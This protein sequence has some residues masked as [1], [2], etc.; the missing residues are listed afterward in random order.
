MALVKTGSVGGRCSRALAVLG[1]ALIAWLAL[2]DLPLRA[3]IAG[4][5]QYEIKAAFL[6]NFAKFVE[7][8]ADVSR[9]QDVLTIALLGRD[10]F[11]PVLDQM[12]T[13]K[14]VRG[15][16]IVVR[17]IASVEE[18]QGCQIVYVGASEER[19]LG[20]IIR[21]LAGR[22][23]LTIGE[24]DEFTSRGGIISFR[25]EEQKVRFAVNLQAAER[26][27][28]TLSSQL[29]RLAQIVT[30]APRS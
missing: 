12:V 4:A 23:V 6:Y 29:L 26:A 11:G 8:P 20:E 3:Q 28:L 15:R 19:H 14:T 30:E 18:A 13:D 7:W 1:G 5:S 25:L 10:P 24:T 21:S 2:S 27:R 16:R 9:G 22:S 17:R